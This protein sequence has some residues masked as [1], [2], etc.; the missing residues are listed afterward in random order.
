[1][2]IDELMDVYDTA[3]DKLLKV[4]ATATSTEGLNEAHRAGIRAVVTALRDEMVPPEYTHLT[5]TEKGWLQFFNEILASD[6]DGKAAGGSTRED[7]RADSGNV[8]LSEAAERIATPAAAPV[9]EWTDLGPE[10]SSSCKVR[11]GAFAS[12][13]GRFFCPSCGKPIAFK[14]E[15]G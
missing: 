3:G 10:W 9:C 12:T 5:N 2:T 1:M 8:I 7:G 11:F 15:G 4:A 14:S 6:G 13:K